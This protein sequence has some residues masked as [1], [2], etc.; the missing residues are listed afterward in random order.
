MKKLLN[1]LFITQEDVYLSRDGENV[2]IIKEN[3]AISRFPIHI[4]EQITC[5]NYAGVSPALIGLCI[6][7]N[8]SISF[9]TPFGKFCGRIT[10]KTSGNVLLRRNQYRMADNAQ[11]TDFTK[12]IVYAKGKNSKNILCRLI[13]DHGQKIDAKRVNQGVD[14]IEILLNEIKNSQSMDKESIRGYEGII[15]KTYFDCFDEMIL[16]QKNEFY[17]RER[18]KRPPIDRVNAM[19][20]FLYSILSLDVQSALETVGIDSYVGFFHTDRPGRA[21]MALDMMEEMRAYL[22]DRLVVSMINLEEIKPRHFEVKENGAVLLND[23]GR[24]LMLEKWNQRKQK[25][26]EHP[27]LKEKHKVG[28]L[29]YIQATLLSRYIRGDLESYPPFLIRS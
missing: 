12:N 22:V 9:L 15:A 29:P 4:L 26:I 16:R 17:F 24:K 13:R 28:L 25:E 2:V 6:E 3:K 5:F 14:K 11:S 18:N 1:T 10:G 7:N 20:S 27:F 21:S 19:L 8:V 23:K